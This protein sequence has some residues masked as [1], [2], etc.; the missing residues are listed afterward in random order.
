M[1]SGFSKEKLVNS[2]FRKALITGAKG[3][4][5]RHLMEALSR[6]PE[7]I[8]RGFDIDSSPDSLLE[9]LREADVV[10]HLAGV[11]RPEQVK[12]YEEGNHLLTKRM[13]GILEEAGR[14]PLLVFSSSIQAELDN[15]YGVSKRQA[16]NVLSKWSGR[17][18]SRVVTFRLKNVFGKWCRPNY[19]SV[20]A[21]FCH[22]VARGLPI[23]ISDP[24][25]KIE[26]VYIDDVIS[27][28]LDCL[29]RSPQGCEYRDVSPAF[30]ITLGELAHQI[31]AFR[32]SRQTLL[33]P[34]SADPFVKRLYATYLSYLEQSDFAYPLMVRQDLR[35]ELAEFLK[36]PHFGQL[37]VSR[38]TPGVIRGNHFHHTKVEKFLVVEGEAI[39]HFR[40]IRA[41]AGGKRAE[42]R[43]QRS[44][45][46][47]Y[48]V[49]GKDFKVLDI[50]PGYT[51][52]IENVGQNDLIVLFWADQI[53]DPEKPDT[54]YEE[55]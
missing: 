15:P 12:E 55:V 28:F 20:V 22:N 13:C 40:D 44:E 27:A 7:V 32:D 45:V 52:S 31:E 43:G 36:Q 49:S 2:T 6:R 8:V 24:A 51:H 35:G 23:S 4:I 30:I 17:T 5:G 26:I 54:F 16:E 9:G 42:D 39:I 25:K 29:D 46:I 34:D 48:R 53:F 21:T 14:N 19:N 33:I 41:E 3:F 1:R 11:N 47:E 50:P 37:F 18:G 10:F 38:T